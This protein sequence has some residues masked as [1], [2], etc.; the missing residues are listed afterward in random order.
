M[1]SATISLIGIILST[2]LYMYLIFRGINIWLLSVLA[3]VIVILFSGGD[4]VKTITG[5]FMKSFVG[6]AQSYFLLFVASAIFGRFIGDSGIAYSLGKK[7]ADLARKSGKH[8]MFVASLGVPIIYACL[9][10]AGISLFVLFFTLMY[11]ARNL[12]KELNLP[13]HLYGVGIFGSATFTMGMLPGSP[14]IQNLIPAK[15]LGSNPMSAPILGIVM[16]AIMIILGLCYIKYVVGKAAKSGETYLETG[17]GIESYF[18]ETGAKEEDKKVHPLWRCLLPLPIPII[19][20]NAF[21]L[22]ATLALTIG[23]AF[24]YLM[25]RKEITNVKKAINEATA[26]AF[27]PVLSVCACAG[28]GGVV[29]AQPGFKLMVTALKSMPGPAE[30]QLVIAV[31]VAAGI[32]GSASAG[33]IIALEALA[34]Q[35]IPLVDVHVAH[36]LVAPAGGFSLLPH[37]GALFAAFAVLRVT[38]REIYRHYFWLGVVIP[39]IVVFIGVFLAQMGIK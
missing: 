17:K 34:K 9:T 18:A 32:T 14:Q 10:Y 20:M 27:T 4:V 11:I 5:P 1:D 19:A 15:Y 29:A 16:A 33:Q 25:F 39:A 28:F 24:T 22:D 7:I 36:R 31:M 30:L 13:W 2:A 23:L 8:Q 12:F 37:N 3:S 6:F 26:T 21:R 35:Y 38:H